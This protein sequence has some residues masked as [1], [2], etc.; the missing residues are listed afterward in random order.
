LILLD[1]MMPGV[2][3]FGV[4]EAL[5]SDDETSD[6]PVIV[7]TAKEL[8]ADERARLSGQI[9]MLMEKGSF[10]DEELLDEILKRANDPS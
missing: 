7:I 8:T 10:T 2:D 9:E 4:L 3:G 1:L 6:I 5:K